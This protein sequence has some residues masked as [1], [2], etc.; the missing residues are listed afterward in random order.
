MLK[1]SQGTPVL[2]RRDRRAR[3]I[4]LYITAKH[5]VKLT[6]PWYVPLSAGKAI[7]KA[8]EMWLAE[9]LAKTPK[10]LS[11]PEIKNHKIAA[12]GRLSALAGEYARKYG[13]VFK[14]IRIG[15]QAT[16]WGSCSRRGTL[17][18]NWRLILTPENIRRYVVIHEICHLRE[19]NHSSRFWRLVAEECPEYQEC[20]KWLRKNKENLT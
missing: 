12:L 4:K 11:A 1:T 8:K 19:M 5:E 20:R 3:Q 15:D 16:R 2:V 18:F 17:S 13:V 7:I 6:L 14:N 10:I 9:A